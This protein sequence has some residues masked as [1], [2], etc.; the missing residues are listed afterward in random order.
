MS[1]LPQFC[2]L[3]SH[4][5]PVYDGCAGAVGYLA[6]KLS[7]HTVDRLSWSG[8]GQRVLLRLRESRTSSWYHLQGGQWLFTAVD[9]QFVDHSLVTVSWFGVPLFR[10]T[11]WSSASPLSVC[12]WRLC[13]G[14]LPH[15]NGFPTR[16]A[17][18]SHDQ[19]VF[20]AQKIV[21]T[22]CF[23]EQAHVIPG[24]SKLAL[25]LLIV[26][27]LLCFREEEDCSS[28]TPPSDCYKRRPTFYRHGPSI[29]W[30]VLHT[31][32]RSPIAFHFLS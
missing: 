18:Q 31:S 24:G 14:E 1:F 5:L 2:F 23:T 17:R 27:L 30:A 20:R 22:I 3:T 29:F 12:C 11:C 32:N 21:R 15:T 16:N 8:S 10:C 19:S 9:L 26:N 25:L 4:F 13:C 6:S 7:T 28:K